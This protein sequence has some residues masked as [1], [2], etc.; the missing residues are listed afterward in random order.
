MIIIPETQAGD[1]DRREAFAEF[2]R[3]QAGGA[4]TSPPLLLPGP[5]RRIYVRE[6]LREDHRFRIH[7]RPEGAEEKFDKL[8]SS[9]FSFFRGTALLYYRDHAGIDSHLPSVFTVGD[10]H[11]ENFGVMPNADGAPF[12]G[13]D[14]FDEACVA[15]FSYDLRRGALGFDIAAKENGLSKKKR[16]KVVRAFL[17]GYFGQLA[18]FAQD[19]REKSHQYRID[20]SPAMIRDLLKSALKSRE[21]FL[22]ELIDLSNARFRPTEEIV[23]RSD[24]VPKLQKVI[25]D[26]RRTNGWDGRRK[27]K[28][29]YTVKDVAVKRGSGTASL[30]L[31]R[32]FVLIRGQ[33]DST[34]NDVILELKRSRPSAL[35]GLVPWVKSGRP[36]DDHAHAQQVARAHRIHLVGGDRFYGWAAIDGQSFLVR[37]RSPYKNDIDPADLDAGELKKYARI[38]GAALAQP[39]ARSDEDTGAMQGDAESRILSSVDP[40]VFCDDLVRFA[41]AATARVYRDHKAFKKDHALGAFS[42]VNS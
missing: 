26:Y 9:P 6:T 25:H 24:E 36:G 11:P 23:P 29:F 7:N 10:V 15:P 41:Q 3:R 38:C 19:D 21:S 39:H 1:P 18:G 22:E 35:E 16:R 40:D 34:E 4:V 33:A 17:R 27:P 14:D 32:Y 2:A 42:I 31:D 8:A 5:Q 28:A 30:G 13:V 37:E 20:N 12:F